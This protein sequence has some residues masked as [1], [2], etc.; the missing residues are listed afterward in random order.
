MMSPDRTGADN[1]SI[2]RLAEIRICLGLLCLS[3]CLV[4]AGAADASATPAQQARSQI[5]TVIGQS[6]ETLAVLSTQ[7]EVSTGGY[8]FNIHQTDGQ[9]T[10]APW[11]LDLGGRKSLGDTGLQW[12]PVFSGGVGFADFTDHFL[13]SPLEGN[14]SEYQTLAA[15]AALGPRIYL[16]H[17]FSI[18]PSMGLIYGYTQNN[19]HAA[20]IEGEDFE[21]AQRNGLVDWHAQTISITPSCELRYLVKPD[22]W[23]I[24]VY[25]TYSYYETWPIERSTDALSFQSNSAAWVN[26]LDVD[27]R[28]NRYLLD[29]PIH[30][31]GRFSRTDLYGGLRQSLATNDFYQIGFRVTLDVHG[32][33]PLLDRLG[34]GAAY[35]WGEGFHGY[36][37]GIEL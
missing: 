14:S 20:N 13:N 24:T 25:S 26:G 35:V 7:S 10:K 29:C 5:D 3:P 19:F 4:T 28:T 30:L 1:V 22:P 2:T 31:G 6:V 36:T 15:A 34:V 27:Y 8:K 23:Q 11:T 18:L 32:K 16:I 9:A 21:Q 12:T 33:I 37:V 17:D